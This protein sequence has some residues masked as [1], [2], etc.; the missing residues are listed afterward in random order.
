MAQY[1][2]WTNYETWRM[3]L[4]MFDGNSA[5]DHGVRFTGC[6][7]DRDD[8]IS[9]LTDALQSRWEEHV[10]ENCKCNTLRGFLWAFAADVNWQEIAEHIAPEV[11]DAPLEDIV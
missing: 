2:G 7:D 6:A 4:E 10:E 1:N 3:H 9:A 5:E 11:E 8:D